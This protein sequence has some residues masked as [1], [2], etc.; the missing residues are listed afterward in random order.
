[1]LVR[2]FSCPPTNVFDNSS[3]ARYLSSA[4]QRHGLRG[5]DKGKYDMLIFL[6]SVYLLQYVCMHVCMHACM[7]VWLY[8]WLGWVVWAPKLSKIYVRLFTTGLMPQ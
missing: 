6:L 1:M 2:R 7:Y 5:D 4:S 8:V 3:E